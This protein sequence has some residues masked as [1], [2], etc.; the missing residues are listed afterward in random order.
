MSTKKKYSNS[1]QHFIYHFSIN[2]KFLYNQRQ[3]FINFGLGW[4]RLLFKQIIFDHGIVAVCS[5]CRLFGPLSHLR[6][7]VCPP[8]LL[9]SLLFS[10]LQN[11]NLCL[12]LFGFH[13]TF[14]EMVILWKGLSIF[15]TGQIY[16]ILYIPFRVVS[17][18]NIFVKW[19]QF[20]FCTSLLY[21]HASTYTKLG[22]HIRQYT[23]FNIQ[24]IFFMSSRYLMKIYTKKKFGLNIHIFVWLAV[25][26]A[27]L[28]KSTISWV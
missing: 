21:A 22:L 15:Q 7:V 18:I 23:K 12:H 13:L 2:N 24:S 16:F 8:S 3:K 5:H 19:N 6:S 28:A 10:S 17:E 20:D 4:E 27:R 26:A 14:L 11:G 9:S 25:C 1:P